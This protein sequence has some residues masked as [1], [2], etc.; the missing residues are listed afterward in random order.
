MHYICVEKLLS[1]H[2]FSHSDFTRKKVIN[3]VLTI[4]F[5]GYSVSY[6]M[7]GSNLGVTV[8]TTAVKILE[9]YL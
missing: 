7:K 8:S 6:F 9:M 5:L 1:A 2:R 4:L 3:K